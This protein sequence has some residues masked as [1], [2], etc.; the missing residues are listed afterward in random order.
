MIVKKLIKNFNYI[1]KNSSEYQCEIILNY[2][3]KS[4]NISGLMI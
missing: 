2:I 3:F 1:S 4:K